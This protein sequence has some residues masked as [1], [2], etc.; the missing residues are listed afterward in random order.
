MSCMPCSG[1][2]PETEGLFTA[3]NEVT[4][5]AEEMMQ[6]SVTTQARGQNVVG[7]AQEIKAAFSGL[8]SQIN[9]STFKT[10]MEV[11][12]GDKMQDTIALA[13]EMDDLALECVDKS[14][15]MTE[16]MARGTAS[17]PDSLKDEERASDR[18][19]DEGDQELADLDGDIAELEECTE[20]LQNMNIFSAAT[21]GT[22]AFEGLVNKG[23][24]VQTTFE[25]IKE[26]CTVVARA[27]Q[28]VA[29][30]TCCAQIQA[31]IDSIKAMLQS[32]RLSNLI[33]KLAEAAKRLISAIKNLIQVAWEKFQGFS[34][35]FQAAKKIKNWVNG[36]N[37]MNSTAENM[38]KQ[39]AKIMESF[40]PGSL[41][42]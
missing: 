22:R 27:A 8:D 25:R 5:L 7:F 14:T 10:I 2:G 21:K 34:E 33:K 3:G 12:D 32:V 17:L 41:W 1:A 11:L 39:G 30:E 23:G 29:S 36:I 31:G 6:L 35:E 9:A 16:T 24:V 15:K 26:L 20:N 28:N 40:N 38:F 4:L 13:G 18:D 19:G 37:P 42:K